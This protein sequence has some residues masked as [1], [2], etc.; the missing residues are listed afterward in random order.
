MS[1]QGNGSTARKLALGGMLL[2]AGAASAALLPA[3]QTGSTVEFSAASYSATENGGQA[4]ITV[5]RSGSALWPVS[6]HYATANGTAT[7]GSDYTTASGTLSWKSGD[8]ADKSFVVALLDDQAVEATET[9]KLQLS[10]PKTAKLGTVATATLSITDN[11]VANAISFASA[12]YT[13]A[14]GNSVVVTVKRS[15]ASGAASVKYATAD[16]SAKAGADYVAASG[17]LNWAAGDATPRSFSVLLADDTTQEPD[18]AFSVALSNATG[19][20]LAAP[21]AASITIPA[22]DAPPPSGA[23]NPILFVTQVPVG[24]FLPVTAAFGAQEPSQSKA[25]RGGDLMIR[26]TDGSLRNLTREA[27]YGVDGWQKAGAIAVRQPA[28]HWNGQK[29]VFSM[30]VGGNPQQYQSVNAQWQLYE[31]TGLAQ[32][33]TAQIVKVPGQPAGYNNIA[34]A[35]TSD[36]Q[37]I[38]ASDR[39]RNGAAHLYPQR[40]EYESANVE[41]G[42]W[43]LD[44]MAQTYRIL[45]HAPSGATYPSVDSAGRLIFTKWDHLL[46]DQQADADA[47]SAASA[48]KYG[49]F[50]YD[51][52]EQTTPPSAWSIAEHFPELR[53]AK[54][55]KPYGQGYDGSSIAADYPFGDL[56]FNHFF[57]WMMNQDGS[58]E[59]T[60]N[61]V[62]RHEFGGSYAN[63]SYRNDPALKYISYGAFN[64]ATYFINGS[65]GVFH[66]REDPLTPGLFYASN[67]AEFSVHAA[68][69]IVRMMGAPSNNPETMKVELVMSR[70]GIG[71]MRNPLPLS[72]GGLVV[73]HSPEEG[74]ET[75][76]A[77]YK[78]AFRLRSTKLVN[79]QRVPDAYLTS[80]LQKTISWW[81]PDAQVNWSGTLWELDPVEV[82]A[83]P[84]PPL[85]R[86]PAL[87]APEQQALQQAGVGQ[88]LLRNWLHSKKLSLVVSRN[89]TLRDRADQQQPYNLQVPGGV[90]TAPTPNARIYPVDRQQF[91][92]ADQIRGYASGKPPQQGGTP[93]PGRRVLPVPMHDPAAMAANPPVPAAAPPGSY[94]IAVDGSTA[95][96]VPAQRAMAWQLVDSSKTGWS[97]AVVRERNWISF[98]PGETRSC[99]ACHGINTQA[100]NGAP[101]PENKPEAL[102]GL[103]EHWKKV[104]RNNCPVSGGTGAWTY[105]GTSFSACD[106][107]RQY[108]IQACAGGNGCCAG[109]PQ[110]QTQACP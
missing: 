45:E 2:L 56:N 15:G 74:D 97:Q 48:Y 65:G 20:A 40:D 91:F 19:A 31:V 7:A 99:P 105:S 12:G 42:L 14:E 21:T 18:E 10:G 89:V 24:G 39:P 17:T 100:Q 50:N 102:V 13:A 90:M 43:K 1:G 25:P 59:E 36:N 67:A 55:S 76:S 62:G 35:Y 107:G 94:A 6:V 33:Q 23:M 29:A 78:H 95:V 32:G 82:V 73:A 96:F 86:A 88:E 108:R 103:L 61:H 41:S 60:L 46:R 77:P 64:N 84:V 5:R 22:N 75:G 70:S 8:K 93:S 68:G 83:R 9:I 66:L 54:Y 53:Q 38:F 52:E 58:E 4:T 80:G 3:L 106:D 51:S 69:D 30:V 63:P 27:G 26:Y 71:R 87:P 79:G 72:S 57:P 34:P 109:L 110:T 101:K 49:A 98:A 85:S 16:G 92:Q 81:S 28:V 11:D 44:P 37:I 104:V 47:F